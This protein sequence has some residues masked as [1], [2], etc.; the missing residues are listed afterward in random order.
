MSNNSTPARARDDG[1]TVPAPYRVYDLGRELSTHVPHAPAHAPFL[2]RL[3]KMHGDVVDAYG[4]S[5][6]NDIITTG[7]HVGTHIDGFGHVSVDGCLFGGVPAADIQNRVTG[8]AGGMGMESVAPIVLRGVVA[9]IPRSVGVG[10]LD[11]DYLVTAEDLERCLALQ[12][13]GVPEN[14]AL[15]IRTGWGQDWPDVAYDHGASPGPGEEAVSWAWERGAR[16]FGSDTLVF[17]RVPADGLPVHR[18]LLVERGA[19]IVEALDLELICADEAWAFLL[20]L[21]PLKLRGATGSPVRPVAILF[22]S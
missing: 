4:M 17:E 10:V 1:R 8:F 9:D 19:H 21:S 11:P 18:S 20:V 6:A 2:H 14:G 5:A 3:Q 7:T 22:D 15:F 13:V 12:A 16:L